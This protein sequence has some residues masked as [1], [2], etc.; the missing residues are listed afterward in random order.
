MSKGSTPSLRGYLLLLAADAIGPL[1]GGCAGALAAGPIGGA[2]GAWVGDKVGGGV[3]FAVERAINYF[4]PPI[5]EHWLDWLRSRPADE[6][7][8]AVSQLGSLP[9]EEARRAA[10]A[11]LDRAA[12]EADPRDKAVALEY[13]AAI[14]GT[15]RRSL[16]TDTTGR[17][18]LP[19]NLPP[20][21]EKTLL[22]LLPTDLPPYPPGT[23]LPRT[24]YRLD[25]LVGTGGF[26]AVYRATDP[27]LQHLSLAIKF[28]LDSRM[29]DIL[30]QERDN[31]ER[32]RQAGKK[33][34]SDRIVQLYGYNLDHPTPFLVYE[35]VPGGNLA[36]RLAVGAVRGKPWSHETVLKVVRQVAEGLAFAHGFG[37][38]HRDLKPANVLIAGKTL[39]LADF[40]IGGVV[41]RHAAGHSKIGGSAVSEL[42]R[43]E[44]VALYRGTGTPLYM[45]PEQR[46]GEPP[47]PRHDLYSLGVLWYQLLLGDATRELHP[48][49]EEELT[50]ETQAPADHLEIIRRCVGLLK[51]RPADARELLGL[52]PKTEKELTKDPELPASADSEV[53]RVRLLNR[54]GELRKTSE[55]AEAAKFVQ[56][57]ES[58]QSRGGLRLMLCASMFALLGLVFFSLALLL[59]RPPD[60]GDPGAGACGGF[61]FLIGGLIG[62]ACGMVVWGQAKE[63]RVQAERQLANARTEWPKIAAVITQEFPE[64]VRSLGGPSR[65]KETDV[66]LESILLLDHGVDRVFLEGRRG[67]K[68]FKTVA[69]KGHV[70]EYVWAENGQCNVYHDGNQVPVN[71][72]NHVVTIRVDEGGESA[73][74]DFLPLT[75]NLDRMT[76]YKANVVTRNGVA[77]DV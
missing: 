21:S 62:L 68:P 26:G 59:P 38:V 6:Q 50:D 57:L 42:T 37:L 17:S 23:Q 36:D 73:Q 74:Y 60:G 58:T 49:W 29:K 45:S 30:R 56:G 15:V 33:N 53:R 13:L 31:L 10:A 54:L 40:G 55:R 66:V 44:Q 20:D 41:A 24:T 12:P 43:A 4:G 65:L 77:V 52:F 14:P 76:R 5:V 2:A 63:S 47:D 69:Y 11:A 72:Q 18:T 70:I 32:L 28:C 39:K 7:M 75:A 3:K 48:A 16:V 46:R 8:D 34:W 22:Q 64:F 9:A 67:R 35:Y 71:V 19:P 27:N 61:L 25:E 51:K 1:V